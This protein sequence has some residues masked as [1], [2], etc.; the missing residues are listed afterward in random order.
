MAG[1][2]IGEILR[3]R[4]ADAG[5]TQ[6]QLAALSGVPQ[7][8]IAAYES[9]RRNPA[10]ETLGR[11]ER[12]LRTPTLER[13]RA[14]RTPILDAAQRRRLRDVR[15]FGSVARGDAD[16]DSDVDLLVHPANDA[17]V[18]DL[19]G[20]M[21]EVE[22]LLGIGVDVVSDRGTGPAMERIRSEAVAL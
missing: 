5:L 1:N 10:V 18:F 17:S 4:R 3:Q 7:P 19:A 11:L 6:R 21:S 9:G 14:S 16:P 8:N 15:V 20:F 2:A 12:V 22:E 13:L